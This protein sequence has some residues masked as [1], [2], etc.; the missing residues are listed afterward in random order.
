MLEEVICPD[1]GGVVGAQ[2]GDERQACTCFQQR[3]T[4]VYTPPEPVD[5]SPPPPVEKLCRLC[6][7][8]V[9]G[10]RRMKDSLGYLC[11]ACAKADRRED[12]GLVSCA[13]CG[14]RLKPMGLVDYAGTKICRTCFNDH[15]EMSKFQAPPPNLSVYDDREKRSLKMWLAVGGVLLLII[16]LTSLHILH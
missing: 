4:P 7:K 9:A 3:R 12:D 2:P 8:N 5:D 15:K 16:L 1:C 14:K 10:H 11:L 13:E 6:G